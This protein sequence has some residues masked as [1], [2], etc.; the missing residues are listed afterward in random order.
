VGPT[1]DSLVAVL[2]EARQALHRVDALADT[3]QSVVGE[4]RIMLQVLPP[5]LDT[6]RS[7][8]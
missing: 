6:T 4:D 7:Q 5:P 3:A 8:P 2:G 1:A